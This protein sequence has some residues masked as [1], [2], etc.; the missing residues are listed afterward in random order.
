MTTDTNGDILFD[1]LDFFDETPDYVHD[2]KPFAIGCMVGQAVGDALGA[3]FEFGPANRYSETFPHSVV[4]GVG[5]MIGGGAF[6]WNPGEFT[7]DTQMALALAESFIANDLS[8]V[9]AD[10]FERFVHWAKTAKD[11]GST[12][13]STL[14]SGHNHVDAASIAHAKNKYSGGNGCVMRVSPVGIWGTRKTSE[15]TFEV[16]FKQARLTHFDVRG[17]VCSG[18]AAVMIRSAILGGATH[19][20]Q[21]AEMAVT[22]C[23]EEHKAFAQKVLHEYSPNSGCFKG[24]SNGSAWVCLAQAFWSLKE[25]FNSSSDPY[26]FSDVVERAINLGGDTDTVAAVAGSLAGAFYGI[27]GIPSRWTTYLN[28]V[29]DSPF[30]RLGRRQS[31][32]LKYNYSYLVDIA[33][34]LI[35]LSQVPITE[36]D[37]ARGPQLVDDL[38]VYA[39]N[40]AGACKADSDFAVLSLCRTFGKLSHVPVR[41]EVYLID[42]E[43]DNPDLFSVVLD[44][45]DTIDEWLNEGRKVLV[46]CHAGRSRTGFI[47][48]AWMMHRN[49]VDHEA[50][51][52]WLEK[53]WDLYD[54]NG[55]SH[56]T[57]FLD[58]Y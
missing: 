13:G 57:G 24:D 3:P 49:S 47:L 28:G 46:H 17:A 8:Y 4:G 7:D 51:H 35:G 43:Y 20:E 14:F 29:V 15:E 11:V 16:A 48:K 32:T 27:Q 37:V 33:R 39:S 41:R 44:C 23:P 12:T 19:P 5:E 18:L 42:N 55:N 58:A 6:G 45:I 25:D 36:M 34:S 38:G 26:G 50:A 31:C 53:C 2:A 9:P 1:D 30:N 54:P 21:L 22:Q 56:F 52:A 10:V 40:L